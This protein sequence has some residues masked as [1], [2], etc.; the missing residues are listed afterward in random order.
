LSSE[1]RFAAITALYLADAGY[2]HDASESA[3]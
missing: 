1:L 2:E 3:A